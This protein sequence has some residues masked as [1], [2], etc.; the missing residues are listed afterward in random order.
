MKVLIRSSALATV[1]MLVAVPRLGAQ[2]KITV[3]L[4]GG[5]HAGKYEMKGMY[6]EMNPDQFPSME[7]AAN[8]MGERMERAASGESVVGTTAPS[9]ISFFTA[10]GKGKPDG[11]VVDVVFHA[12]GKRTA[13]EIFAIPREMYPPGKAYSTSGSGTL[14]VKETATGKTASF[15]GQTKDGVKMEGIVDC[16]PS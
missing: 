8:S 10:S 15:R 6:C 12:A 16:R 2:S 1:L 7:F 9:S 14:T 5:A 4:T 3:T 13:Y 11:F